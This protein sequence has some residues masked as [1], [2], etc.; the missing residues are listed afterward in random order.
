[1]IRFIDVHK[2][3]GEQHVLRGVSLQVQRRKVHF[4]M[5]RSGVG[6]SV[7]IKCVVG[8]LAPDSG[9]IQ[10]DGQEITGYSEAQFLTLR[11][12]C[13][14]VFQQALLFDN[15]TVLENVAGPICQRFGVTQE[16]AQRRAQDV[17]KQ[18]GAWAYAAQLPSGLGLGLQKRVAMARALALRPE[19]VLFDEPTTSLDPVTAR[20]IDRVIRGICDDHGVTC[21]VVSHDPASAA[22][23]A[24]AVTVLARGP[25]E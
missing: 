4:V 18:L 7:L 23:I 21:V 24:D 19:V 17:L 9:S 2:R 8:L 16:V 6:K 15:Q 22:A 10:F 25:A 5:G 20:R 11:Q 13:Q 14:M 1:M 12:R 3:F